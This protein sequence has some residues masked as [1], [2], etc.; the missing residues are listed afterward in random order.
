MESDSVI[1]LLL[2]ISGA[3]RNFNQ[4][5]IFIEE[6][7]KFFEYVLESCPCRHGFLAFAPS[8]IV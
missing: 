3:H 2:P 6:T 7:G 4:S 1:E 5:L 8:G